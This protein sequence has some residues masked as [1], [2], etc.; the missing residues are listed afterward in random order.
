MAQKKMLFL[1]NPHAGKYAIKN[2]LMDIINIFVQADYKI[3]IYATQGH[4]DAIKAAAK[5]GKNKDCVVCSG[6][7]GTLN[8]TV[9]GLMQ[10]EKRPVIGYIPAGT[11]NDFAYTHKLS[12][13]MLTAAKTIVEGRP[14]AID[15]GK[16]ND[17]YFT[18]VAGFGAFTDVPYKTP[19]EM[20]AVLGHPAYLLEGVKRLAALTPY[21]MRV[22]VDEEVLEEEFLL[23]LVSNSVRVA[24]MKGMQGKDVVTDD[25][26]HEV[27]LVRNPKNPIDLQETL[28]G[29]FQPS[30]PSVHIFRRKVK[31]IRFLSETAVDWVLDGEYGGSH[32]EVTIENIPQAVEILKNPPVHKKNTLQEGPS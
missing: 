28:V 21:R 30:S 26:L 16:F 12:K 31:K 22:E 23:G 14:E 20:K 6:G 10:L 9:C 11:T 1:Y 13:N 2:K 4:G 8:E 29:L 19:Q 15:L 7:D 32:T 5:Y 25:G 24:G 18:Y 27:L 3:Q 17:R